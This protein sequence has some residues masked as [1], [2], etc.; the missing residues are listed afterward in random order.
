MH[1]ATSGMTSGSI[2]LRRPRRT[3]LHV[4]AILLIPTLP[5]LIACVLTVP[6]WLARLHRGMQP[7]WLPLLIP[8]AVWLLMCLLLIFA[9]IRTRRERIVIHSGRREL[10]LH[11][12]ILG[13][14][15]T[16]LSASTS[17]AIPFAAIRAIETVYNG[18]MPC[19][20]RLVLSATHTGADVIEIAY[21]EFDRGRLSDILAVELGVAPSRA[22]MP[23]H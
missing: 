8:A 11:R 21:D 2:V 15:G 14:G 3:R 7:S 18:H 23:H 19:G 9:E 13:Y 1:T 10:E 22:Q 6:W 12:V 16:L 4:L 5:A 20:T 17:R